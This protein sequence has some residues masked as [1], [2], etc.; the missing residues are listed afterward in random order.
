M[1]SSVHLRVG[2]PDLGGG[3][4]AR[5]LDMGPAGAEE[6]VHQAVDGH[7]RWQRRRKVEVVHGVART[8][9][10]LR[11]GHSD[12]G[13]ERDGREW[14]RRRTLEER[15]PYCLSWEARA[16]PLTSGIPPPSLPGVGTPKGHR[17]TSPHSAPTLCFSRSVFNVPTPNLTGESAHRNQKLVL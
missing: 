10:S 1:H 2:G 8:S 14:I 17:H 6:T 11:M 13:R 5:G 16:P 15:V 9:C 3:C 7:N 12:Q 4:G